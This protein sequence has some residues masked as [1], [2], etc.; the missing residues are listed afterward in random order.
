MDV[1]AGV[2]DDLS[3]GDAIIPFQYLK[4]AAVDL[5]DA[6]IAGAIG[7]GVECHG[8]EVGFHFGNGI[9]QADRH[10]VALGRLFKTVVE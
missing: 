10:R 7:V 5:H 9:E 6:V 1:G 4:P 3:A 8:V 2:T